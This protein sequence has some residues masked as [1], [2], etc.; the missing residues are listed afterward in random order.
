MRESKLFSSIGPCVLAVLLFFVFSGFADARVQYRTVEAK[1]MGGSLQR[2][3]ERALVSGISQINGAV[4]SSRAKSSLSQAS[5]VKGGT[6]TVQ[7][8]KSFRE[9]ISKR[10]KGI[11]KS[12]EIL[13]QQKDKKT[14]IY[15]VL[16]SVTVPF[17]KMS[18]QLKRLK[19]AVVPLRIRKGL[20]KT[21]LVLDFED[22][23]RRGLENYLTQTRRFAMLDRSFI[24]EQDKEAAFIKG[25]GMRLEELAR[26]GNRVGTDYIVTGVVERAYSYVKKTKMRTTGQ[27]IKTP[28][29]GARVTYRI[30]DVASTQ[31]KLAGTEKL[32]REAGSLG[33]IADR[34]AK[35]IG[36]KIVNAIFPISVLNV[37][38]ELLTLGQGGDTVRSGGVYN[39]VRLGKRMTDPHTGESL[40]RTETRV[41][42]VKVIDT[43]SKMSTGKILKL[44]ISRRSLL[45][46]DFIIRPRKAASQAQKRARKM[47]D[48]EKEMDKEF[49]KD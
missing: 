12:Y 13:D 48:F 25:G 8:A 9:T 11:V 49:D 7:S 44:M 32:Q 23:F 40:G 47:R 29:V 4:I 39:L 22:I 18:S 34:I 31:V 41:G 35:V 19:M 26:L 2:A 5:K 30:L 17:F 28:K 42:S 16:L 43:Q 15:R 21:R 46:D 24:A 6:K 20:R 38:G 33:N 10:T 36:Q 27:V 45:R 37:D 14:G 3:V 1:G